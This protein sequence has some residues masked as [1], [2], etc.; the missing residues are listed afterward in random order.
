[1]CKIR[2]PGLKTNVISLTV[3]IILT[4]MA[5][6]GVFLAI[7]ESNNFGIQIMGIMFVLV[8]LIASGVA[9]AMLCCNRGDPYYDTDEDYIYCCQGGGSCFSRLHEDCRG[10]TTPTC[11]I[12][13]IHQLPLEQR[14]DQQID[15]Q[16]DQEIAQQ[17]DQ[18]LPI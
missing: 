7:F 15:Q 17:I 16:N 9:W 18:E 6:T 10:E 2:K 13:K 1:M 3:A 14:I 12:P 4:A 8:G 11:E 5:I